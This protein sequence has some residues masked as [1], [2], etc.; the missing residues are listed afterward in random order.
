MDPT[1]AIPFDPLRPPAEI[2]ADAWAARVRAGREQIERLREVGEPD[3][4][5][6]PWASRFGR[7]P[8]RR[9]DAALEVLRAMA[10]GDESWLDIGAGGGRYALPL[11]LTVRRVLAL[12]PSPAMLGVLRA[13]MARYDIG[14]VEVIEG[15]WPL[16]PSPQVD[17]AL[18]AHVGYDIEAFGVFLDAAEAAAGR[19][20]V[21]MRATASAR[22]A[23]ALWPEVHGEQRLSYPMLPELL[24][25][26][27]ARGTVP[28]VTLVERGGWG[29]DSLEQLVDAGM[30]LL[31]VRPD[32]AKG[33]LAERLLRERATEREGQ[34]EYDWSPTFDGIVSWT[35]G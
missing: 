4:F 15:T 30:R 2:A 26:L 8:R 18:V 7:D 10:H 21:V 3:D 19:C 33:R 32:G 29:F 20:V 16:A 6:G 28:E 27:V 1:A 13:G 12:D 35:T 25:L 5:Y 31:W 11:A 24:T 22:T 9:G 17:V 34:W 23:E 14:N